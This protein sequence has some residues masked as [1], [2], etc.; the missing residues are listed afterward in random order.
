MNNPNPGDQARQNET[1]QNDPN[2]LVTLPQD[3]MQSNHEV[4]YFFQTSISSHLI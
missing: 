1:V 4:S 3:N 2:K